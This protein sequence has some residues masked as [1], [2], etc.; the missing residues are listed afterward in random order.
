MTNARTMAFAVLA[1]SQLFFSFSM[2]SIYQS[3]F[4]IGLFSNRYLVGAVIL[5]FI[6]QIGVITIPAFANAFKVQNLS[7]FNWGLVMLFS[8]VPFILNEASKL[9]IKESES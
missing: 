3:V 6:L 4:K 2:R 7:A 8:I 5:G 9:F 1:G